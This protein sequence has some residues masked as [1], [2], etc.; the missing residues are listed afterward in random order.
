[1]AY[2]MSNIHDFDDNQIS[3][4]FAQ[5]WS[6][7]QV[8]HCK[9]SFC[10]RQSTCLALGPWPFEQLFLD[11]LISPMVRGHPKKVV[12]W[13]FWNHVDCLEQKEFLQWNTRTKDYLCANFQDIWVTSKSWI[14]DIK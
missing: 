5:K 11:D 4:K 14:L 3:K 9:N 6:F 13:A 7:V 10:S 12:H 2:S 8:F 1:M